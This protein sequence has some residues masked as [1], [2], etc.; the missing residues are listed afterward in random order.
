MNL[1]L[2]TWSDSDLTKLLNF[3]EQLAEQSEHEFTSFGDP[4]DLV[5]A[6]EQARAYI[7]RRKNKVRQIDDAEEKQIRQQVRTYLIKRG[8]IKD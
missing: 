8:V 2:Q 5:Q 6:R 4:N 7:H 3:T 1:D